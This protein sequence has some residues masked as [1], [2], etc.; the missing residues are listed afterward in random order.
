MC[1]QSG[2]TVRESR[3]APPRNKVVAVVDKG[4]GPDGQCP[5]DNAAM[6][7]LKSLYKRVFFTNA[8]SIS[9]HLPF[10]HG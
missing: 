4:L 3:Y 1:T 6:G 10:G 2:G 7:T 8:K 9:R 5:P